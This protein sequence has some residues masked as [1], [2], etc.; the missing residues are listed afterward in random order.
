M[1]C[2]TPTFTICQIAKT[3]FDDIE[4][5]FSVPITDFEMIVKRNGR[6]YKK[7]NE[8]NNGIKNILGK[9]FIVG[10]ELEFLDNSN[11]EG[12]L[13]GNVEGHRELLAIAKISI[14]DKG[15]CCNTPAHFTVNINN[16]IVDISVHNVINNWEGLQGPKGDKGDQGDPLIMGFN[17]DENMHLIM[18]HT[19]DEPLDFKIDNNNHLILEI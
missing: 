10:S 15:G 13:Y 12:Y 3:D 14:S 17:V 7:L 9:T 18:T 16:T 5:S 6:I 4:I 8:A 1:K 19:D 11:Y 2:S